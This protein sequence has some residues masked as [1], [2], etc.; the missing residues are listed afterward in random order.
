VQCHGLSP[1]FQSASTTSNSSSP[2]RTRVID[3]ASMRDGRARAFQMRRSGSTEKYC[4]Q[5]CDG[6]CDSYFWQR[7]LAM[8]FLAER[9]GFE[10]P[11]PFRVNLIS[12]QAPSAGLGH[13]SVFVWSR[14]FCL[15]RLKKSSRVTEQ[16]SASIPP[17]TGSR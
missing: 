7:I 14:L 4:A 3:R 12:S 17:A 13:L 8:N 5:K 9:E 15:K 1:R 2:S 16:S 10:P 6:S 11:S